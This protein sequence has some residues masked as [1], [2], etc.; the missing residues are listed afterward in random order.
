MI[1][2]DVVDLRYLD[3]PRYSNVRYLDRVCAP[4][5]ADAVRRSER[6][7]QSLAIIWAAKEAAF[8]LMSQKFSRAHFVPRDFVGA[9]GGSEFNAGIDFTMT[10][11]G[12]CSRILVS[13]NES[14]VHAI[15]TLPGD[16]VVCWRVSGMVEVCP[17]DAVARNESQVARVLARKLLSENGREGELQFAGRIPRVNDASGNSETGISLSHHGAYVAAVIAWSSGV[18]GGVRD[19][20]WAPAG[21]IAMGAKCFTCTA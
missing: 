18:D 5:E 20:R 12:V 17:S 11:D 3:A 2:N 19:R 15:A 1:G 13:V 9:L 6:P 14:W 4:V 21:D 10:C 8:K 16:C 7:E